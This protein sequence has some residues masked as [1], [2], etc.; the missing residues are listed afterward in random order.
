MRDVLIQLATAFLG[1]FGFSLMFGLRR[2]YVFAASLGGLLAWAVYLLIDAWLRAPFL[3]Y[4]L[5]AGFAV[6]Y[7]ELLAHT[8]K[9]PATLF[10]V[11]AIVPL[12]PGSSLYYAMNSAVRGEIETAKAFGMTTLK[13]A[14][15][16][17]AG[18]SFVL[19]LRE[20]HA[21]RQ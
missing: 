14:L 17:A 5:A 6:L 13:A 12:V 11:P 18:I 21:K 10:V 8:L 15:A 3:S 16:I 4:L 19:A 1:A 7:S 20:L 9:C 2:R